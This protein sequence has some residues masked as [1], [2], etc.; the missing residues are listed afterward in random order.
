MQR[1]T[2]RP[3]SSFLGL[4]VS[5]APES[6]S[7]SVCSFAGAYGRKWQA[8]HTPAHKGLHS[9]KFSAQETWTSGIQ[10]QTAGL[11]ISCKFSI[12]RVPSAP[13]C[14]DPTHFHRLALSQKSSHCFV[15]VYRVSLMTSVYLQPTRS[16]PS[17]VT[18]LSGKQMG[19]EATP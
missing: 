11:V 12:P 18:M 17:E 9:G 2:L 6:A 8:L 10:T 14:L 3:S 7:S 15:A 4:S 19:A 5:H 13:P 16:W 1:S